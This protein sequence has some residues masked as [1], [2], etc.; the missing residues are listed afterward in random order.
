[1]ALHSWLLFVAAVVVLCGTPG[2]N[3]LH[4][5]TR[6]VALGWRGSLPAMAGCLTALV[7][8]LAASAAGLAA[9]LT[10][11]PG[12]FDILRYVGAAYLVGLGFNAWRNRSAPIDVGSAELPR[13]HLFR[14]GFLVGISNPKL[15]LFATAFLPQFIDRA[16]PQALQFAILVATFALVECLWYAAY[17]LGGSSLARHLTHPRVRRWFDRATG[18]IFIGFGTALLI[19]RV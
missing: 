11:V 1:M 3:M 12:L 13:A 17:A 18:G 16:Q 7:T 15:L 8:V 5:L 6:S 2:P 4:I 19:A 9:V 10:A 14:G